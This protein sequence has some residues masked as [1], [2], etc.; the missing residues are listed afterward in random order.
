MQI[1][2]RQGEDL[3]LRQVRARVEETLRAWLAGLGR[4]LKKV[5]LIPPDFTR[6]HSGAGVITQILYR[7]LAPDCQVDIM[8]ALGTHLPLS[9]TERTAMFGEI[10]ADRFF[11]H[12][13]RKDLVQIGEVPSSRLSE[14]SGG[15]VD[16]PVKVEVNK[17]LIART[18][19]KKS[20]DLVVSIGQVVPHEV[21][22]MANYNK[23]IFVGCGGKEIIDKSHFL[24][25]VYGM[26]RI[27][28][29]DY[30]PPR[31]LFDYA[32]EQFLG[33][34]PLQYILT[35]TTAA[36]DGGIR[37]HGL[38][39]GRERRVFEA[40]VRLSQEHNLILLDRPLPKV[41]VYL[42]PAEFK[43]TWLGNKAVYRLRM[44]VADGG[45]L[46]IIAPG[47]RQ[48][49]EDKGIDRLIRKYGYV[50]RDRILELVED[51]EDLRDNL[52][53]A[54]HLIHGS[55]EGRFRVV[56]A[57]GG[58]KRDE[59]EQVNFAYMDLAEAENR[60][61][62]AALQEGFN[63]VNGEEVYFVKNPGL[64]LWAERRLFHQEQ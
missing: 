57:P 53:A 10:P 62:P 34:M 33:D 29:R 44:A 59:I 17:R 32:E 51:E 2:N 22:G 50:G 27:M 64:G 46:I 43:S 56:Y 35:V 55:S 49:G 14:F 3:D 18:P 38:F 15:L 37:L 7:M 45:E 25:A 6:Y 16:Y 20:Y 8:P 30:S 42:D 63:T 28:G 24:G 41:V 23:N 60:Y 47:V 26:E 21:V 39:I 58:L 19:A 61:N 31:R 5:L 4:E 13:W 1:H 48:F 11:V 12:D 36:A 54:A 52:S 40:A 9:E